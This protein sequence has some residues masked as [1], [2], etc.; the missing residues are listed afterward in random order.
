[1]FTGIWFFAVM[2]IAVVV[3]GTLRVR[4][5]RAGLPADEVKRRMQKRLPIALGALVAAIVPLLSR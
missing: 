2:T 4:D 3:L 5:I 1:M